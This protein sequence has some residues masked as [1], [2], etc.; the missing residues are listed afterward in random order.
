[1][2]TCV[3]IA[4][5]RCQY[6]DSLFEQVVFDSSKISYA[7]MSY[8]PVIYIYIYISINMSDGLVLYV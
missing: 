3:E 1:M 2:Y 8:V 7:H 6:H 5:E 4:R